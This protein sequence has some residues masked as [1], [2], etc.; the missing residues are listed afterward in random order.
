MPRF[1][2]RFEA[3]LRYRRHRRDLCRTLL[4]RLLGEDRR[5]EDER[6]NLEAARRGQL[7]ELRDL[8]AENSVDVDRASSR[9]YYA[10]QLGIDTELL[11][12]QREELGE[13]IELCRR[14]LIE[15]DRDV[16]VLEKL[17]EKQ[18]SE[19]D[20]EQQRRNQRATEDVWFSTHS[21][22]YTP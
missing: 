14:T 11:R 8:I 7:T 4:G 1:V 21:M 13:R 18:R 16:K 12:R 19:F 20:A 3:L 10:G 2:F 9:R 17:E 22:E 15:A 5:L 6:S